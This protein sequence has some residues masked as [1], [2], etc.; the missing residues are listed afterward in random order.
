MHNRHGWTARDDNGVKREIRVIKSEGSWRFQAKQ[1]GEERWSYY[2]EPLV[3]DLEEFREILFRKYQRRRA[4]YEDVQW[5]EKEL[6]RRRCG[7]AS[8]EG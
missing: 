3:E 5:A 8:L 6:A 7:R 1:A 4:A 2:H